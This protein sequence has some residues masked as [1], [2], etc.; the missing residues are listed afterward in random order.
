MYPRTDVRKD[1]MQYGHSSK[2]CKSINLCCCQTA[3][4]VHVDTV[5]SMSDYQSGESNAHYFADL[6]GKCVASVY[7]VLTIACVQYNYYYYMQQ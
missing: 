7:D 6:L 5:F 4:V 2:I 1:T 3:F